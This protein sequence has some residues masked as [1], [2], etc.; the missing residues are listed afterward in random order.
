MEYDILVK[1]GTIVDGTG[2][3]RFKADLAILDGKIVEISKTI[4]GSAVETIRAKNLVVSPGFIDMHSHSDISL[5]FDQY[6]SSVV[7]QGITTQIVG[8][9]GWSLAPVK[10]ENIDLIIKDFEIF[11]PP[12]KKLEIKWS[13]FKEYLDTVQQRRIV[14]N[15]APLVG[16]GAIRI[17]GG[18]G[19]ED[20]EP[21]DTELNQMKKLVEEAMKAGAWGISTGLVY[22]PQS[23]AKTEEIIELMKVAAKNNRLYFSHIRGEGSNLIN[24]VK[25]FIEI[26]KDSGVRG[27]QISHHKVSG[28]K[29]WG[30]SK[31]SLCLIDNANKQG[32]NISCDQY[33]FNRGMT[34]LVSLLPGWVHEG[35]M[36]KLIERLK[37]HR[38]RERI[39]SES[40]KINGKQGI[41]EVKWEN[42]Y[43]A[44][45]KTQN[46]KDI[47]GLSIAE[48]SRKK[49]VNDC[50]KTLFDII[51]EEA[52]GVV[53]HIETMCEE[54]IQYIMKHSKTMF[55]TDG[56]GL[57]PD[58]PMD[59]GIPHPRFYGTFPRILGHYVREKKIL[60]LEQ[61]IH[62]MTGMPS[63]KLGIEKRGFLLKNYW[64]DIV[65]FD[66]LT[67]KNQ[68]TYTK[69][70][71]PEG[72]NY[73]TINGKFVVK[74]NAQLK[75]EYPGRILRDYHK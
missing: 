70:E 66:P 46:W 34:S 30:L 40:T 63:E 47:E 29:H 38:V 39:K 18:L 10:K 9:C 1:E 37:D 36:D 26:V 58:G 13:T 68:A 2:K 64:A 20:R 19:Y 21:N 32:L 45:V 69:A 33:P 59:N 65:I 56:W 49:G 7:M 6:F 17:A 25:E 4:P 35:G 11:L 28:E 24:A 57:S 23:Y 73:V 14:V 43:I 8:N 67:I 42:I 3:S 44:A 54:D 5:P 12:G 61:A 72:I 55:G 71:F 53:M 62:K 15:I 50:F 74:E 27:G 51:L 60:S 41:R 52:G 48:I 22:A 31:E 75:E 16:F